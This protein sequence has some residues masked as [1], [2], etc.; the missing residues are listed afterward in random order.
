MSQLV[1]DRPIVVGVRRVARSQLGSG[2]GILPRVAL[3]LLLIGLAAPK[4]AGIPLAAVLSSR[5]SDVAAA[6][7]ERITFGTVDGR[8]AVLVTAALETLIG[9]LLLGR[10]TWRSGLVLLVGALVAVV[11]PL[12][13]FLG[14]LLPLPLVREALGVADVLFAGLAMVVTTYALR[15]GQVEPA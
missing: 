3:A 13:V 11:S 12:V 10:N 5:G 14:Q 9:L 1:M 6:A 15:P 7:I 8:A 2:P 4:F